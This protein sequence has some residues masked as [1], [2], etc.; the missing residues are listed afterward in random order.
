MYLSGGEVDELR[1]Y[2]GGA[3]IDRDAKTLARRVMKRALVREDGGFP[4][5]D[6]ENTIV[7]DNT[8]A[9]QA[10]SLRNLFAA[11]N[12]KLILNRRQHATGYAY[13]A[14]FTLPTSTARKFDSIRKKDF[15]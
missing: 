15:L 13:A 7:A 6:F 8:A 14:R 10:P 1:D 2:G 9:G 4:L 5:G 3:E 11:E 12:A